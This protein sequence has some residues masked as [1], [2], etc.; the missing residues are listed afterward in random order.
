MT[1]RQLI[2]ELKDLPPDYAVELVEGVFAAGEP[3]ASGYRYLRPN[4]VVVSATAPLVLIGAYPR[5][6]AS[7]EDSGEGK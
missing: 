4:G 3:V 1:V 2:A 5:P 6:D 7:G